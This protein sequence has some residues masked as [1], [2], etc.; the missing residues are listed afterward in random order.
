MAPVMA[1]EIARRGLSSDVKPT[2]DEL[3]LMLKG[4][5]K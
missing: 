4:I 5:G 1:V 2:A 3:E